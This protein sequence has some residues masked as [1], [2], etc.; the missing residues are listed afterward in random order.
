MKILFAAPDR[1]L[2]ECYRQLFETDLGETVTAFDGTQV[3]SLLS[4][5][6]FDLLI[7]DRKIP[8]VDDRTIIQRA[9]GKAVPVVLLTDE[10]G[11]VRN[12]E[13]PLPDGTLSYPFS[14]DRIK[15]TVLRTL[16]TRRREERTEP[17]HEDE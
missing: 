14:F 10:P 1:D 13:E 4:D 2:L 9:K 5:E 3:L 16:E 6:S 15:E 7:L 11:G 8:R 12:G 17:D